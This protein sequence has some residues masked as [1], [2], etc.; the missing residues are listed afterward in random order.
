MIARSETRND[1]LVAADQ[2][3]ADEI[4]DLRDRGEHG[5]IGRTARTA[6]SAPARSPA[7]RVRGDSMIALARSKSFI[8]A[9][10]RVR[11]RRAP[12]SRIIA[13]PFSAIIM[14]GALVLPDVIVG[15]TEAS[16]TRRRS[17]PMKRSRSSTTAIGSLARP[18][19]AVPTGWKIVVP[20]S[21]AALTSAASSSPTEGPGRYSTGLILGERRLR[22][23]PARDPDRVDGDAAVLVGRQI[24]R[25][26][27]RLVGGI[28]GAQ[29]HEAAARRLQV[30]HAGGEGRK[31]VQR[32]AELV[33]RQRLHVELDV[34]A[35]AA[36]GPSA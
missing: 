4:G 6:C 26:D 23:D 15:I 32:I 29:P 31:F 35:L 34:G 19:L 7:I 13:A 36:R 8:A 18:I 12:S 33:E 1:R 10:S 30:A 17:S 2:R 3:L 9:D 11:S 21:P 20:M 24:I 14:V 22:H 16:T 28:G 25:L 5:D 27:H